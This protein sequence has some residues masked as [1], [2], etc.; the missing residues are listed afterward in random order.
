MG[1]P[2]GP[3]QDRDWACQKCLD[4]RGAP[5]VNYHWRT[6]CHKCK[7]SKGI[8]FGKFVDKAPPRHSAAMGVP[9]DPLNPGW[10][11]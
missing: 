10:I 4:T 5:W 2:A 7:S 1:P 6:A 8:A 9:R 3:G 11:Q